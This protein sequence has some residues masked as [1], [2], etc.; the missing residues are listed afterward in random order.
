MP[1][2]WAVFHVASGQAFFTGAACL[3]AVACLSAW[4][5]R[6]RGRMARNVL[7]ALGG[8]LVFVSATPLPPW[9]YLLLLIASLAW[10]AVEALGEWVPSR[11]VVGGRLAFAAA[12]M[13]AAL[14]ELPYH[15][16]PRLPRQPGRPVLGIIGDSLT[17]GMEDR[18]AVTWPRILADR[19]GVTVRDHSVAGAGVVSASRQAAS[20]S[21]DERLVLL[22]IGGNDILGGTSPAEFEAGLARLL[23]EIRRPDRVVVMLELP[24]PPTYNAFGLAQRRL[25]RQYGAILVPR[26]SLLGVLLQK[27]ATLDSIHLSPGGHREMAISAWRVLRSAYEDQP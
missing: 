15:R 14:V 20:V 2:R 22:E 11:L 7:I 27:D 19:H 12:W 25:A 18:E 8:L 9:L 24:L 4:I 13:S 6:R 5:T 3:I 23:A 26:R 16:L 21:P 10:P 1:T 17:A